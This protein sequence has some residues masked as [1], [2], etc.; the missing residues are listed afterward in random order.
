[1]FHCVYAY[2]YRTNLFYTPMVQTARCAN[3]L[4]E[5]PHWKTIGLK[6]LGVKSRVAFYSEFFGTALRCSIIVVLS[7]TPGPPPNQS[8]CTICKKHYENNSTGLCYCSPVLSTTTHNCI[9][10][11]H[12]TFRGD[13]DRSKWHIMH[14][15]RTEHSWSDRFLARFQVTRIIEVLRQ[16]GWL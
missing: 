9:A 11:K 12:R 5:S 1:M 8:T 16:K 2:S 3:R 7:W 6:R 14:T 4:L 13:P 15:Y 10:L